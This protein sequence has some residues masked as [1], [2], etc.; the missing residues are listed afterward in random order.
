MAERQK[1]PDVMNILDVMPKMTNIAMIIPHMQATFA[2]AMLRQQKEV[3]TFLNQRC[4][5]DM[6]LFDQLSKSEDIKGVSEA[7]SS[8][9]REAA[10]AYVEE[11][12]KEAEVGSATLVE[13]TKEIR[14]VANSANGDKKE[15][16]AA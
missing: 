10:K 4:E 6:E 8:F 7:Y 2:K 5:A 13:I 15:T 14:T 1:Q 16:K 11:A 12:K 9:I 3:L